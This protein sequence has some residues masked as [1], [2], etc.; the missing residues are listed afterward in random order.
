M[1]RAL[2]ALLNAH[3]AAGRHH[4]QAARYVSP[5]LLEAAAAE[6]DAVLAQLE[7]TAAGLTTD[8][9]KRRRAKFGPNTVAAEQQYR[10]LKLFA[11]AMLNPLVIL[12]LVLAGVSRRSRPTRFCWKRV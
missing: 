1:L 12:L 10:R 11:K 4:A 6:P 3:I 2:D 8:E 7:T 5:G 9:V